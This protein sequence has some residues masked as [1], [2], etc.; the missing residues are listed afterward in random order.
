MKVT[1]DIDPDDQQFL[2]RT[3]CISFWQDQ[4]K[5]FAGYEFVDDQAI[6]HDN[7]DCMLY[8][9][10]S[11]TEAKVLAA[12]LSATHMTAFLFDLSF[13]DLDDV[14]HPAR[15]SAAPYVVWAKPKKRD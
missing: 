13:G 10:D 7:A 4:P 11:F 15:S 1:I 14:G 2:W 9:C 6:D 5:R 3:S 8:W 12:M